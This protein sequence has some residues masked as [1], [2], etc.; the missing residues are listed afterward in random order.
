MTFQGCSKLGQEA[1]EAQTF[2]SP[3][4]LAIGCRLLQEGDVT[5]DKVGRRWCAI[6]KVHAHYTFIAN[7]I[8]QNEPQCSFTKE[9]YTE[10]NKNDGQNCGYNTIS[11]I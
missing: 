10:I 4:R 3:W 6:H 2:T 5:L 7:V 9:Y 8:S 11:P 1:Q